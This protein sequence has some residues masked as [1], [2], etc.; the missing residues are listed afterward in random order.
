MRGPRNQ[1]PMRVITLWLALLLLISEGPGRTLLSDS[2]V[3]S[4]ALDDDLY[5]M[6]GKCRLKAPCQARSYWPPVMPGLQDV[7]DVMVAGGRIELSGGLATICGP[8]A[9]L[10][11][12]PVS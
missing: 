1:F 5:A 9:A 10:S 8:Q 12:S 11:R 3:V 7:D 4:Q 6:G 2:V